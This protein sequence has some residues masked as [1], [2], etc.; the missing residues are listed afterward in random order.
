MKHFF[1]LIFTLSF[2]FYG[3][4]Q[5]TTRV[6]LIEQ[7]TSASC[8]PCASSN[9]AFKTLIDANIEDVAII[10]YQRGGGG[11]IDPM[12][13]FNPTEVDSRIVTYYGTTSFPNVWI[14]GTWV[15]S[16]VGVTQGTIDA[17]NS[18]PAYFDVK[19]NKRLSTD[20]DTLVIDVDVTALKDFGGT[21]DNQIAIYTVVIER[22]VGYTTAPGW[23]GETDFHWVMRDMMP[24][25]NGYRIGYQMKNDN[26]MLNYRYNIDKT[27]IDPT[28]LEVVV[29]IQNRSTKE[30]YQAAST[31]NP[32]S[33][34][35]EK[36][37]DLD[38][39]LYPTLVTGDQVELNFTMETVTNASL[40]VYDMKGSL[41]LDLGS[42]E[43]IDGLNYQSIPV[44]GLD[45]GM[46]FLKISGE[47]FQATEKFVINR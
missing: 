4:S 44:E 26:H 10:K 22:H 13:D 37:Q 17:A 35:E 32:T 7:V 8:G 31:Q 20:E 16:P 19:I 18:S 39:N 33:S 5:S 38:I 24:F 29:F 14:N 43:C 36:T 12:W 42:K 6:A 9:P 40:H 46:Y 34:I 23:N 21:D 45:N 11:Y 30:V 2:V 25:T 28:E 41:V 47:G 27:E 15:G 1:T 3:I